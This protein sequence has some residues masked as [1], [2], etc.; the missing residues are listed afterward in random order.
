MHERSRQMLKKDIVRSIVSRCE[1]LCE[2][3]LQA[4][5]EQ[6]QNWNN[7]ISYADDFANLCGVYKVTTSSVSDDMFLS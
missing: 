3:L 1:L 7:Y 4:E 6:G 5:E 2:D